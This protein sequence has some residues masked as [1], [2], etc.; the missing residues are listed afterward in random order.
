MT[1]GRDLSAEERGSRV[2]AAAAEVHHHHHPADPN[3]GVVRA[4]A[5]AAGPSWPLPSPP[6]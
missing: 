4:P 3:L 6:R 2:E 5:G 1:D